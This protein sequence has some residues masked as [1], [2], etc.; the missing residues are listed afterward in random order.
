MSSNDAGSRYFTCG[1][2]A[3]FV[4]LLTALEF[5]SS[6]F[7]FWRGFI[8]GQTVSHV[9]SSY[10]WC[11]FFEFG[12]LTPGENYV[13][14]KGASRQFS[15]GG[16]WSLTTMDS[17]PSWTLFRNQRV[18][19]SSDAHR[20]VRDPALDLLVVRRLNMFGIDKLSKSTRLT[21]SCGMVLET[22]TTL[23]KMH[24]QP[25]WLLRGPQE[26]NDDWPPVVLKP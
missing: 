9:W 4:A 18:L 13:D 2:D 12:S 25:H 8:V 22:R 24:G 10:A 15:P 17:W 20:R 23:S 3:T 16:E 19:A 5:T 11:L 1:S 21:F 14:R 26:G 7:R 6:M